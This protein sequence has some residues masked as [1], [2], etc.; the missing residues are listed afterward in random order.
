ME[1]STLPFRHPADV[2]A[3]ERVPIAERVPFR[4]THEM[5]AAAADRF[6]ERP[7][8]SH[9]PHGVPSGEDTTIPFRELH[10]RITQAANLFHELG[11]GPDDAVSILLPN[12]PEYQYAM[13]GAETAGIANPINPLLDT[14]AIAAILRTARSRVLVTLAPGA[15]G[16][17]GGDLWEKASAAA[18]LAPDLATVVVVGAGGGLPGGAV[19]FR[20]GMAGC[21]ADALAFTRDWTDITTASYFHTGG[22]TGTPKLVRH[23]HRNEIC[24]AWQS[25]YA[26]AFTQEDVV[27]N[28]LPLFHGV[29]AMLLSLA[30]LAVGGHVVMAG[31]RGFRNPAALHGFWETVERYRVTTFSAVPTVYSA[32]LDC[33]TGDHDISSL[34]YGVCGA[35]PMPR[36]TFQ[37]FEERT[38]IKIIEGYGMTESCAASLLNPRDGERKI[39]AVGVRLPY[40]Q[41]R[42]AIT[43]DQG[44][45][46]RDADTNESGLLLMKGPNITLG[47]LPAEANNGA[48]PLPGW[49]DT[50]DTGRLDEDG[51]LYLTG[52]KKDLI[53]R[54]GHNIDPA[55]VENALAGH[56]AVAAVAAVGQ[57]DAYAGE[58]PVAY[59]QLVEGQQATPEALREYAKEHVAERPAAPAEVVIVDAIP[60]TAVGKIYK[61]TLREDAIRRV[62]GRTAASA[63][64]GLEHEVAVEPDR[65]HGLIVRIRCRAAANPRIESSLAKALGSLIHP[66]EITWDPS[67]RA[68]PAP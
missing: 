37:T 54:S 1:T 10:R 68:E 42:I 51:Y 3:V 19:D 50:G 13:W 11:V 39:G 21:A 23:S 53:I 29:G 27:L 31:P 48:W 16:D 58:L 7:A 41:I 2:E 35:A 24:N 6:P 18:A 9:L 49:L 33:P 17:P 14:P 47:Y 57:P 60:T 63:L 28:G 65:R 26:L 8:L 52:R 30:P 45:F 43:D 5:L 12:L 62:Y 67:P 34:R 66:Y 22:T 59:V 44:R 36:R 4:S 40:Q 46:V 25:A 56:P 15:I 64:N 20:D 55:V 32:L 38:G 61:P